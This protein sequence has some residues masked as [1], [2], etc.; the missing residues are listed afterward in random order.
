LT[1]HANGDSSTTY[2]ECGYG[3]ELGVEA[4]Y[5]CPFGIGEG[6]VSEWSLGIILQHAV[7]DQDVI[8][9]IEL[10]ATETNF[11]AG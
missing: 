8:M 3:M 5:A 2:E 4:E 7:D 9:L 6:A 11:R 10:Y 1:V